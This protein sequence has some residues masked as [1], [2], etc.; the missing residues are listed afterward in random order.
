MNRIEAGSIT[1]RCLEQD[2]GEINKDVHQLAEIIGDH[3]QR[4]QRLEEGSSAHN[5]ALKVSTAVVATSAV[6]ALTPEAGLAAVAGAVGTVT[7]VAFAGAAVVSGGYLAYRG[8][9]AIK[10]NCSVM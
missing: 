9:K 2:H 6:I 7:G 8:G 1:I 4:L 10:E 3:E 5:T